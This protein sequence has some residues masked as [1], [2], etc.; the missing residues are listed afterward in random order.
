M[1]LSLV[2]LAELVAGISG[3]VF[4]HEVSISIAYRVRAFERREPGTDAACVCLPA[5]DKGNLP[6]DVHRGRAEVRRRGRG[7][8]R[9]RQPA[10]QG[11]SPE[12]RVWLRGAPA[13]GSLCL[14][15]ALL[16]R[17]QL[18]QLVR[19]RLLPK[20]RDPRQLLLQRI[21]LQRGRPAQRDRGPHQGL[22][23]GQPP[24]C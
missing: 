16:R 2:F 20:Q 8:S 4:R 22:P 23:P 14:L 24:V 17:V 15:V 11:E 18:H 5:T 19:Q 9:R 13:K 6:Q 21:R 1:F 12:R 10:A 3:F 7:Q